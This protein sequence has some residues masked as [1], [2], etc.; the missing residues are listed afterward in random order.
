M[1]P[2]EFIT[3]KRGYSTVANLDTVNCGEC[4]TDPLF[5]YIEWILRV[6][7]PPKE[8]K[9]ELKLLVIDETADPLPAIKMLQQWDGRTIT[10]SAN[11]VE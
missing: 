11:K 3:G 9:I 4:I 2:K 6:Y 7:G 1:N 5:E 10:I 8:K